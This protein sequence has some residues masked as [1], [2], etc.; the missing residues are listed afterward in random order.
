MGYHLLI[1]ARIAY[2]VPSLS[3]RHHRIIIT[4]NIYGMLANLLS[5]LLNYL[6]FSDEETDV[7]TLSNSL[8]ITDL[9]QLT[10]R[11]KP[12]THYPLSLG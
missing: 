7:K 9:I 1:P 3:Y 11:F 2:V 10:L 6:I 5:V 4:S 12:T 8:Q